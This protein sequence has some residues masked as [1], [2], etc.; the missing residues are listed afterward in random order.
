[1]RA[2]LRMWQKR[3]RARNLTVK[4]FERAYAKRSGVT[5]GL[6]HEYGRYGKPCDCDE[7][8][9]DGWQMA[10]RSDDT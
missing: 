5:V 1:M 3:F 9:C 7:D 6:L 10:H 8:I 2:Y 4:S